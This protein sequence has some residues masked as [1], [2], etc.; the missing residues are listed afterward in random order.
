ML[1]LIVY[2]HKMG[3]SAMGRARAAEKI[4]IIDHREDVHVC[5]LWLR[6]AL[7]HSFLF[8]LDKVEQ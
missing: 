5:V 4:K 2:L 6:W 1:C 8:L 3:V 7:V